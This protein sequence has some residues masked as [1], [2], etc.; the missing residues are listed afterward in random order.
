[1]AAAVDTVRIPLE[2]S[3]VVVQELALVWVP[4]G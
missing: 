2:Q 3:D 4:V 1:V